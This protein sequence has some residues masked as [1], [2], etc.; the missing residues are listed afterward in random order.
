[1]RITNRKSK[2]KIEKEREVIGGKL[3]SPSLSN[4]LKASLNSEIWSSVSWSAIVIGMNCSF[5]LWMDFFFCF[6]F[7]R[8]RRE[9]KKLQKTAF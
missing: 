5:F 3:P 7:W 4:K 8:E 6:F 2:E 1:M 9:T